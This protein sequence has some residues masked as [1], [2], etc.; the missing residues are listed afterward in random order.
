[1]KNG[2]PNMIGPE[3]QRAHHRERPG[4]PQ[5]R[6]RASKVSQAGAKMGHDGAEMAPRWTTMAAR[7]AKISQ[8]GGKMGR[9]GAEIPLRWARK[10]SRWDEKASRRYQDG[11]KTIQDDAKMC[12]EGVQVCPDGAKIAA[13]VVF[14]ESGS[15]GFYFSG[16]G[17]LGVGTER[18]IRGGSAEDPRDIRE[19]SGRHPGK[20]RHDGNKW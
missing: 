3:N 4:C 2:Y 13:S 10:A 16:L 6:P 17:G 8:Q 12:E 15:E 7:C 1:M 19:T 11:A 5:E 18:R 9:D 20:N 14:P